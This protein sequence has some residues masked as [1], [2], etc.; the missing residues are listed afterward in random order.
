MGKGLIPAVLAASLLLPAAAGARGGRLHTGSSRARPATAA[1]GPASVALASLDPLTRAVAVAERY[2]G[3]VPCAGQIAI[4]AE[5]RVPPSLVASTDAWVTFSSV[6]G[7]NNLL[8]P[9]A[10]YGSC[11]VSLAGW[12]WP[13]RS[14]MRADWNMFCLTVTHEVGHLLGHRHSLEPGSVMAPVFTS[15]ANVPPI[16]RARGYRRRR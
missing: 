1:P 12:Q 5:Q 2:W 9:A 13:G 8:A 15:E 7:A 10:S 14:R 6:L 11:V 4:R 3:A 16:C